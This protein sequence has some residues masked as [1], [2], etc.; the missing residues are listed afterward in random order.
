MT[1][2]VYPLY[3]VQILPPQSMSIRSRR[4]VSTRDAANARNFEL[5]Q[6]DGKYGTQNRPDPNARAP[7][8]EFMPINSRFVDHN[9]SGQPRYV[10]AEP[11]F[12][13]QNNSRD[14]SLG[15]SEP[16]VEGSSG[17]T[18]GNAYF[19][20]YATSYDS[21]NAV[22]DTQSAVYEDKDYEYK[23]NNRTFLTRAMDYH[24]IDKDEMA[25]MADA[26]ASLKPLR[27][28]FQKDYRKMAKTPMKTTNNCFLSDTVPKM[29]VSNSIEGEDQTV[30]GTRAVVPKK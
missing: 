22:R 27:D 12:G 20:K 28:D 23:N 2:P 13:G 8:H 14:T 25:K 10:P 6:T 18:N 4:E 19:D 24:F 9:Y 30:Y 21:R 17:S 29:V 1:Q 11:R 15:N 3:T 7:F 16:V 5:W 26:A